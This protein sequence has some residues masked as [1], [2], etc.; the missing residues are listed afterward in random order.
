M[1]S[2]S[3]LRDWFQNEGQRW[4]PEG[5]APLSAYSG[6][7]GKCFQPLMAESK[8]SP[9][10]IRRQPSHSRSYEA[11]FLSPAHIRLCPQQEGSHLGDTVPGHRQLE[12]K[13]GV[14]DRKHR[15]RTVKDLSV[16]LRLGRNSP[17]ESEYSCF[18][19]VCHC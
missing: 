8:L 1:L 5:L 18:P 4:D 10:F 7:N 13:P 15:G 12:K 3:L 19:R 11:S 16:I 17:R 6:W 14:R 9:A 2:W